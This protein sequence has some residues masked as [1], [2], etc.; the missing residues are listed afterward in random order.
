LLAIAVRA[1]GES[2]LPAVAL[3]ASYNACLMAIV[4]LA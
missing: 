4:S 3:H 2:L 1:R